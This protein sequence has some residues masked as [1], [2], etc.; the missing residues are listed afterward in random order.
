MTR[1]PRRWRSLIVVVVLAAVMVALL[2]LLVLTVLSLRGSGPEKVAGPSWFSWF[3]H[4]CENAPFSCAVVAGALVAPLPIVLG[5]L[6]LVAWRLGRVRRRFQ[7]YA[8]KKAPEL[9]QTAGPVDRIVGRDALCAVLK[10]NLQGRKTRVPHVLVGGVGVGKTAVLVRMTRLLAENGAVPVPVRLRDAQSPDELD[11]ID[12]ARKRFLRTVDRRV[13]SESEGDKIWRKLR[14]QD[15]IV[16]LADGLE[17][18]LIQEEHRATRDTTIRAAFVHAKT[19]KLPLLVTSRPH[20][21]LRYL[22]AA[23]LRMEPLSEGAA[24]GFI[25][26][27][28]KTSDPKVQLIVENA[29]V[30]EA[31]LYMNVAQKLDEHKLL[32]HVDTRCATRLSLRIHMLD[33]WH[34]A[35]VSGELRGAIPHTADERADALADLGAIAIAGLLKDTLEVPFSALDELEQL[36]IR[37]KDA[38][39]SAGVGVRLEIVEA[40]ADGV[41][42]LHSIVQAYLGSRRLGEVCDADLG[43]KHGPR[44]LQRTRERDARG[45]IPHAITSQQGPGREL[46]MALVM[47]CWYQGP[48]DRRPVIRDML[49]AKAGRGDA[50]GVDLLAAAAEIDGMVADRKDDWIAAAVKECWPHVTSEAVV[51]AK[52]DA[53][54]RLGDLARSG[55]LPSG[56]EHLLQRAEHAVSRNGPS[57]PTAPID[58]DALH[59]LWQIASSPSEAY[60]ARLAAAQQI[61]SAGP[62]AVGAFVR[63]YQVGL[64]AADA[65]YPTTDGSLDDD[66]RLRFTLHAWTL[67][68]LIGCEDLTDGQRR[69]LRPLV[70]RWLDLVCEGVHPSVEEAWARG[71]KFEA[72]RQ[73]RH[74][75]LTMRNFLAEEAERLLERSQFWFT[76][77]TL[78]HAFTLWALDAD[79]DAD[80]DA[81]GASQNGRRARRQARDRARRIVNGWNTDRGHVFVRQTASLCQEALRTRQPCRYIW[82]DETGVAS[83]VGASS[84]RSEDVPNSRLWISPAAGW[85]ALD[86]RALRLVGDLILVLNLAEGVDATR[87]EQR[88]SRIGRAGALPPCMTQRN[89]REALHVLGGK[90][91]RGPRPGSTCVPGCAHHLCPYA[92]PGHPPPRGELSEAFCRQQINAVVHVVRYWLS[93]RRGV[94]PKELRGF[95]KKME[96]RARL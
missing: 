63:E 37:C 65:L 79:A 6:A 58:R 21:T 34:E 11:F 23:A 26:G 93:R 67:P 24:L 9:V 86:R 43:V 33:S 92:P 19:N 57:G 49:R 22:D 13:Y 76:R 91:S 84:S 51:E 20:P 81:S 10:R 30:V 56:A 31:P 1:W 72:N 16:V 87:R 80:S 14:E 77:V 53:I 36:G 32:K 3:D 40:H 4:D 52:L 46:L 90:N 12:L 38:R 61:G 17:E 18:A 27:A 5:L 48:Q 47:S 66:L 96:E 35:L 28:R 70:A 75:N 15:Q 85:M 55:G 60:G 25:R 73:P 50:K 8:R 29:E 54:A 88:L 7:R 95:W 44:W 39:Y 78:F 94:R 64:A 82:I 71:F 59:A 68:M 45:Q 2:T 89:G 69:A 74:A 41:R 62:A 83:K 42:F